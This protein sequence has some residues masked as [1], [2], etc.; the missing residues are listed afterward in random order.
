VGKRKIAY[1][2]WFGKPQG[3]IKFERQRV[4]WRA[5]LTWSL[6][7]SLLMLHICGVSKIFGEWYKKTNKAEDTNK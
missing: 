6:T 4:S 2:M 3:N 7:L 5:T 1:R